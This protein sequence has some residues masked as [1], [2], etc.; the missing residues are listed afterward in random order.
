VRYYLLEPKWKKSVYESER[1]KKTLED[2]TTV[3]ATLE[4]CWR[5]GKYLIQVPETNEE[6]DSWAE[7]RDV[8][9]EDYGGY[10]ECRE[11]LMPDDDEETTYHELDDYDYEM[12]E[13]WDGIS[14]DWNIHAWGPSKDEV[15]ENI[16]EY[17]EELEEAY[18]ENYN[19]GV[20]ELGYDEDTFFVEIHCP[21][22]LT[23][24]DE[25]GNPLEVNN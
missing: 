10:D 24:C 4:V 17:I 11:A 25:S 23:P 19:E 18:Q 9:V 8:L 12:I 16:D 5:Y 20:N 2:G 22:I 6:L 7:E 3:Y 1:F 21:I 14:E 15:N 13:T